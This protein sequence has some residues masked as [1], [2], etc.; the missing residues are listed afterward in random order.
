MNSI[1]SNVFGALTTLLPDDLIKELLD[2]LLDKAE[3]RIADSAT[4]Y[5]DAILLPI[6]AR[7]RQLFDIPD[8]DD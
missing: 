5:D 7:A 8:G 1:L 6:I 3:E 4:P 2:D